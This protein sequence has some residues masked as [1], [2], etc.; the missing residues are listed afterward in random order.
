MAIENYHV[1]LALGY[2]GLHTFFLKLKIIEGDIDK[3]YLKQ[4]PNNADGFYLRRKTTDSK[5]PILKHDNHIIQYVFRKYQHYYTSLQG[6][7]ENYLKK[8]S[9]K[10]RST[11][12]RKIRRFNDFTDNKVHFRLYKSSDEMLVFYKLARK[13]SE[14]TYQERILNVGLP[15]SLQFQNDMAELAKQNKVRG[16]ILFDGNVP[17]SYLYCPIKAD[18]VVYKYLGYEPKYS[19]W[20]VGAILLWM[21]LESLFKE[22]RYKSFDYTGG[23]GDLKKLF[24]TH[25]VNVIDVMYLRSSFRNHIIVRLHKSFVGFNRFILN[26]LEKLKLKGRVRKLARSM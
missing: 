22:N 3:S 15:K 6:D 16:Y 2:L 23:E 13:I 21:T 20:S 8:F 14:K 9:S 17:V 18:T 1:K 25:S 7:F 24:S 26:F 10:S 4:L 19:K 12:R 11:L 5:V